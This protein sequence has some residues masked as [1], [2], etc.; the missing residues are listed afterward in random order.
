MSNKWLRYSCQMK[1]PQF[2]EEMQLR[3][4]NARVL[5]AGAGGLGCPAALYLAASG[6]G[7]I[8]IADY[9]VVSMSNLHRQV[10][11]MPAEVGLKKAAVATSRLRQ[12]NPEIS[13]VA[14]DVR[15]A[16]DNVLSLI[17]DY[18]LVVDATDNFETRYLLNDAC[19]LQGKPLVYGAIYQYEGQVAVWNVR[20]EDGSYSPNYRDVFPVVSNAGIPDCTEGGVIPTLAG[21]I[22]CMQANEVLKYFMQSAALLTGKMLLF[23]AQTLQSRTISIGPVTRTSISKPVQAEMPRQINSSEL[24]SCLITNDIELIDVRTAEEHKAFNIGG[25]NIPLSEIEND[26]FRFGEDKTIVVYCASGKRSNDAV[27]RLSKKYPHHQ[28]ASLEG[29]L[30]AFRLHQ[31]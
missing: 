12:Q 2:G 30:N 24:E 20:N 7:V 4:Q 13:V 3:L 19:V 21:M 5:I 6:I 23:D 1:L 27:K 10:L 8:G 28:F 11:F 18:D 22:G 26:N 17:N 31:G 29:G 25:R 16:A 15:I 9:D 14:H